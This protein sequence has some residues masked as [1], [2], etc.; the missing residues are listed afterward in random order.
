MDFSDALKFCKQ[1]S[2]ISRSAWGG[3][4]KGTFVVFCTGYPD[5]IPANKNA[6]ES[7]GVPEG[8]LIFPKPYFMICNAERH[9]LPW[10]PTQQDLVIEDWWVFD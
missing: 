1:G 6:S 5:G 9:Q 7:L 8:E 2:K 4:R 10:T 3:K